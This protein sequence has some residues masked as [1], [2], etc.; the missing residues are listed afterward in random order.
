MAT[1]YKTVT[2]KEWNSIN[3]EVRRLES[4]CDRLMGEL[5]TQA[6]RID[7]LYQTML[8]VG[9]ALPSSHSVRTSKK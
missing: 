3:R 9:K 4:Q 2:V 7:L 6:D 8:P 1:H 5:T